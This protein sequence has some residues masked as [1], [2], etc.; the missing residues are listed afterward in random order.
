MIIGG[1]LLGLEAARGLHKARGCE[2]T[3]VHLVDTLMQFSARLDGG[4]LRA[5]KRWKRS[6]SAV[7]TG[8]RTKTLL[9]RDEVE[10]RWNYPTA[11]GFP[12]ISW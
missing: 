12:R 5:A 7:L 11:S 2:V 1:G 3:V 10:A 8:R 6:A 4:R 9:G